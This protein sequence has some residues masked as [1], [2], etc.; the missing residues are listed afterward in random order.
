M[1]ERNKAKIKAHDY[2]SQELEMKHKNWLLD[3][4]YMKAFKMVFGELK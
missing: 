3:Q 4:K 1:Y 2:T